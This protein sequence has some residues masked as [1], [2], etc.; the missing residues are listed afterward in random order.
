MFLGL[1]LADAAWTAAGGATGVSA[2]L[3]GRSWLVQRAI[4]KQQRADS[5]AWT[6]V[7]DAADALGDGRGTSGDSQVVTESLSRVSN[8]Q[9]SLAAVAAVVRAHPGDIDQMLI[10]SVKHSTI[11][12]H[13]REELLAK[14]HL[15]RVSA[16][17]TIEVI[18]LEELT[19]EVAGMV[20][21]EH[22]DVVRAAANA[23][24]E[25][26]PEIAVGVLVGLANKYGSWVLES[27]GRAADKLSTRDDR[28]VPI[29]R[30]LW[31]DAPSLA[32]R[33]VTEGRLPDPGDA[34][35]AIAVMVALL[36]DTDTNR[37]LAAVNALANIISHPGAQIALA[38]AIGVEDRITRFAAAARL[39]DSSEGR[40]ILRT[41]ARSEDGTDAAEVAAMVLWGHE[42][43]TEIDTSAIMPSNP[44]LDEYIPEGSSDPV[45]TL[46]TQ[47]DESTNSNADTTEASA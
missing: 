10:D 18:R 1:S 4:R 13:L 29:G 15:R 42:P 3:A 44:L 9:A 22:E 33:A 5:F 24:A 43:G 6:L 27:L 45:G 20:T 37:R 14:D 32:E 19:G 34:S 46:P 36:N 23:L 38:G 16:L 21:D 41:A 47:A 2:L 11:D 25:L 7:H 30:P 28:R 8:R 26:R 39:V 12:D 40:R 35:D 31:R 17:E